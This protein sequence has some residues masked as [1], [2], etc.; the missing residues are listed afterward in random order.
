MMLTS[1]SF[2]PDY[3]KEFVVKNNTSARNEAGTS[4]FFG[5]SL[6]VELPQYR[7]G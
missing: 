1:I 5:A 4:R 2:P 3:Y 6:S 7:E